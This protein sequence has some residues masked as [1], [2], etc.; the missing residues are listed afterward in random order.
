M[1]ILER[2]CGFICIPMEGSAVPSSRRFQREIDESLYGLLKYGGPYGRCLR[3]NLT[4]MT[5]DLDAF[6]KVHE[7]AN[8]S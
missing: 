8:V 1:S 5:S 6:M 2:E 4:L 3:R 7:D